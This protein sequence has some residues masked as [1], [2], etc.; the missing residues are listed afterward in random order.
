[1]FFLKISTLKTLFRLAPTTFWSDCSLDFLSH[2]L[3]RG[4]DYCLLNVPKTVFGGAKCGNGVLEDGEDCD[5]GGEECPNKCCIAATCK[6]APEA[7][8]ADGDCCDINTCK[9]KPMATVCRKS[10]NSCDLP[11]F[12]DGENPKCPADFFVSNGLACPD[13]PDDYCYNGYCGSRD[14]HCQFIWGK[15]GQSAA[16]ECYLLNQYGSAAGNCGLDKESNSY[17]RCDKEDTSCGRLQ[18]SH[19]NERPE[20]GDPSS[21]FASYQQA[22][23]QDGREIACRSIR[24]SYIGGK[25][26]DP[27]MVADGAKCGPDKVRL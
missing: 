27:G 18:C 17:I 2:A 16:P 14:K 15:S 12:C 5:C 26:S 13:A 19:L 3:K 9:P 11:E 8:C 7:I 23:L 20:F 21:V 25:Q 10:M 24:T 1:M 22:R 6:L 4:A